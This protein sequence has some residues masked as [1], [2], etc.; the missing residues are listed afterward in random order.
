MA[1]TENKFSTS[2][3]LCVCC[4]IVWDTAILDVMA[5]L[6][7]RDFADIGADLAALLL[8]PSIDL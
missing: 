5:T 6:M 7:G 4:V 8:A 3:I 2:L 1:G